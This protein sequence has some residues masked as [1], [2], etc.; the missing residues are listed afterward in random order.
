MS[1][2][3][4]ALQREIKAVLDRAFDRGTGVLAFS[5]LRAV[6][7]IKAGGR[8]ECGDKLSEPRERS[9]KRALKGLV[10]QRTS[11]RRGRATSL[12]GPG[13]CPHL[14]RQGR[15]GRSAPLHHG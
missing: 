15:A 12:S 13:R 6:F 11:R 14:R 3:L 8:P 5:A 1:R 4:G 10:A 9:L 2:G 7:V